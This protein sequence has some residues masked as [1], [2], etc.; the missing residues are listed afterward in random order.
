MPSPEPTRDDR[1]LPLTRYT[2][3]AIVPIV[4]VAGLILYLWPQ[5][6]ATL[7]SWTIDAPLSALFIGS[8]YLMGA[9]YFVAVFRQRAW[10]A[11]SDAFV[12]ISAFTALMLLATV[13]HWDRFHHGSLMFQAWL[14]LYILTPV[15]LPYVAWRNGGLLPATG[16][17]APDLPAWGRRALMAVGLAMVVFVGLMF[18]WPGLVIPL[19]PWALTPLTARVIAGWMGVAGM[20]LL[21]AGHHG[22]W[23]RG[24]YAFVATAVW[25]GLLLLALPRYW[26]A[27]DPARGAGRGI[28]AAGAAAVLAGAVLTVR[29][30]DQRGGGS[31]SLPRTP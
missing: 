5:R 7:W 1:L 26:Q 14:G 12:G 10:S 3:L 9:W 11:V 19:W 27:F 30:M 15:Y 16:G 31:A 8:G 17:E 2:A 25:T 20:S 28:F 29:R 24:R 4:T 13:L 18:A 22:L 21:L 6:T 23:R